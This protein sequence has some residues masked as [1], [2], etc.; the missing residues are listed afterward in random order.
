MSGEII[1]TQ[2]HPSFYKD[3]IYA[4]PVISRRAG[5]LS[6]GINLSQDRFC[7]FRCVYCQIESSGKRPS[8]LSESSVAGAKT[9]LDRLESEL[10]RT[11]KSVL[12]GHLFLDPKFQNVEPEKRVLKDFAFSGDGEPTLSPCFSEAVDRAVKVRYEL[13]LSEPKLVLI[14]NAT[15]LDRPELQP[16]FDKLMVNHGEIWAKF[17]GTTQERYRRMNRSS[18][19]YEKIKD[20]IIYISRRWPIVIQ[21]M[22]LNERGEKP[23]SAELAGYCD[24]LRGLMDRGAQISEIQL[25]TVARQ[26]AESDV[27]ALENDEMDKWGKYT[28]ETL[29]LPVHVFYSR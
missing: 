8:G 4:Y 25:Y 16:A 14:T 5:G 20:N 19:S 1:L 26:P 2:S 12:S 18:V 21:T 3:Q 17:D 13:G 11:A 29:S 10:G 24:V 7:N 27:F 9:D 22:L 28:K 6:I 23:D 15:R